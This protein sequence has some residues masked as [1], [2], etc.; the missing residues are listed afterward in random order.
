MR[1]LTTALVCPTCVVAVVGCML[2]AGLCSL[3]VDDVLMCVILLLLMV[4]IP[5][6]LM[7]MV[8]EHAD[9]DGS[10]S[11]SGSGSGEEEEGLDWDELEERARQGWFT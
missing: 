10:G 11:G 9:S 3:A 8:Y 2:V 4:C 1:I 7:M 5:L 6:L